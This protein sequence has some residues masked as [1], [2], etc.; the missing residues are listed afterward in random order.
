M[1]QVLNDAFVGG[2]ITERAYRAF[3]KRPVSKRA[4][5]HEALKRDIELMHEDFFMAAYGYRKTYRQLLAQGWNPSEVGRDQVYALMRELGI[6]GV[7]TGKPPQT[8]RPARSTGGRPDLVNRN[9]RVQAP[10]RLHVA[11][12]TYVR[13]KSGGFAY[14]AFITDAYSRR[15]VGWACAT[16]L[17][18][19]D[20]ALPALNEALL[21]ASIRDT[22]KGLIHHSDHGVQYISRVYS[23]RVEDYG[24]LPSTGSV[25]DSYDNALA[26]R[27]NNAYKTELINRH[28]PFDSVDELEY[29]TFQWVDWYN[30]RRLHQSLDYKTPSQVEEEYYQQQHHQKEEIDILKEGN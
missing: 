8:T 4:A 15:I 17:K 26:E 12:I 24:V 9:F 18:T 16:S 3:K 14:T 11:D 25:G 19:E 22:T 10:N 7:Y 28:E 20:I 6:Q 5:R 1:C 27:T 2:F 21:W 13:L 23:Q 29:A 30:N